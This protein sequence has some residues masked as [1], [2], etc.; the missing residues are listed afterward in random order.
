LQDAISLGIG[1]DKRIANALQPTIETAR[2]E[3]EARVKALIEQ[4][5]TLSRR[6]TPE[7][8]PVRW[9]GLPGAPIWR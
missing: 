5:L 8:R 2:K 1:R 9:K 4:I 7:M 3:L 6:T